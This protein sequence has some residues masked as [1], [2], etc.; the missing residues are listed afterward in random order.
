MENF[1]QQIPRNLF[2]YIGASIF[3][4]IILYRFFPNIFLKIHK[5]FFFTLGILS[6]SLGY[7][8]ILIPGLP[9]TVFILIAAWAFSKCSD[10]FTNWL[11]NHRLFGPMILNWK[12]YRGLSRRAK[13]LAIVMIVPTFAITIFLVFFFSW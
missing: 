1:L 11:E 13:K 2:L 7:V 3:L 12:T 5:P 10:R 9:T 8:G 4:L 6:L